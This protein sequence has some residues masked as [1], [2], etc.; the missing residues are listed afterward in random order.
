MCCNV[1]FFSGELLFIGKFKWDIRN[2]NVIN[3]II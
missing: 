1:W 3:F 2:E